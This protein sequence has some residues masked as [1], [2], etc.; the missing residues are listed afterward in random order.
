MSRIDEIKER[1][2]IGNYTEDGY[3]SFYAREDIEYLLSRLEIAEKALIQLD[4]VIKFDYEQETW[5][6]E[7]RLKKSTSGIELTIWQQQIDFVNRVNDAKRFA[8]EALKQIR[9]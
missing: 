8:K 1:L 5:T 7:E 6:D 9:E 3:Q 4:K 2:E